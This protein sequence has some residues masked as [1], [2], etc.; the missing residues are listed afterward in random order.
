MGKVA[1]YGYKPDFGPFLCDDS[2]WQEEFKYVLFLFRRNY[3][4]KN[5]EKKVNYHVL[6]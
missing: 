2:P 5:S 1:L 6:T 3:F 4:L